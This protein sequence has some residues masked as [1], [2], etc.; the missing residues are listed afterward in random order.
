MSRGRCGCG[1]KELS[2]RWSKELGLS[3]SEELLVRRSKELSGS[4]R[5][6]RWTAD[7]DWSGGVDVGVIAVWRSE[8]QSSQDRKS[9][10]DL[11][12]S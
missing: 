11:N 8:G 6:K 10:E 12:K 2:V 3:L 4:N 9:D 7:E 5:S 1:G